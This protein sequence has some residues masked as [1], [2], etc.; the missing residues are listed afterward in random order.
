MLSSCGV[1]QTEADRDESLLG[2][3]IPRD[4]RKDNNPGKLE[5]V[6]VLLAP[7]AGWSQS[8]LIY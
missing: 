1:E 3:S 8:P 7:S 6:G 2:I 5:N 4:P